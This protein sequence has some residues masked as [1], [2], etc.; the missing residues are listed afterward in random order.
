MTP[1]WD[2]FVAEWLEAIAPTVRPTTLVGYRQ[3]V[4]TISRY[5][6]GVALGDIDRITLQDMYRGMIGDGLSAAS[7]A[8]VTGVTST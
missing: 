4:R 1:T 8:H 7:V 3:K 5:L 2:G 6:G